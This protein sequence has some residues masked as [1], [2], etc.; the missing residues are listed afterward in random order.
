[1]PW[2]TV[3]FDSED[4]PK[5]N[6]QF[7]FS[8]LKA[9]RTVFVDGSHPHSVVD[10]LFQ[11][12]VGGILE[13]SRNALLSQT[14]NEDARRILD[15]LLDLISTFGAN[16]F[17]GVDQAEVGMLVSDSLS[18]YLHLPLFRRWIRPFWSTLARY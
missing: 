7:L 14:P 6:T 15:V 9:F 10:E 13:R 8:L 18:C 3:P 1:M 12:I 4:A 17:T 11:R 16:L 2:M 5:T